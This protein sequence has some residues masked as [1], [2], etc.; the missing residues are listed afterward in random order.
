MG[1]LIGRWGSAGALSVGSG[2]SCFG[3]PSVMSFLYKCL[4]YE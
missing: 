1:V 3:V 2:E 4:C